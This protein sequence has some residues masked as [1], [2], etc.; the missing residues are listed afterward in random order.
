MQLTQ[1]LSQNNT[2][3]NDACVAKMVYSA[4]HAGLEETVKGVGQPLDK[5]PPLL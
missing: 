5:G 1:H 4:T 3:E 2:N